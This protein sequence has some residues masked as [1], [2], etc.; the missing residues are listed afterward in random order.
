MQVYPSLIKILYK[1]FI[2]GPAKKWAN[3]LDQKC[4]VD[5]KNPKKSICQCIVATGTEV[6]YNLKNLDNV[7]SASFDNFLQTALFWKSCFGE[8]LLKIN[9]DAYTKY[10]K[11]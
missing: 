4:I 1:N 7:Y 10:K 9:Q 6:T 8:N 11:C 3:C 5:P 2:R